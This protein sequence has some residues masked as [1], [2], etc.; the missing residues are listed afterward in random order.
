MVMVAR[1]GNGA[2]WVMWPGVCEGGW[3]GVL[4]GEAWSGVPDLGETV[5]FP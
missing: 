5:V 4:T 1:R 2:P 3:V